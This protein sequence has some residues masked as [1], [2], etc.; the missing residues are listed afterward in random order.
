MSGQSNNATFRGHKL[1]SATASKEN[2]II[3]IA[4]ALQLHTGRHGLPMIA[5]GCIFIEDTS[6]QTNGALLQSSSLYTQQIGDSIVGDS[7]DIVALTSFHQD[8]HIGSTQV[9]IGSTINEGSSASFPSSRMGT[10]T[11]MSHCQILL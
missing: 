11:I 1:L 6:Y 4:I 2:I 5:N 9:T 8:Q 7:G 3:Q 10:E